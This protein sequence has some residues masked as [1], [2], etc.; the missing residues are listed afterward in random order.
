MRSLLPLFALPIAIAAPVL[1]AEPVSVPAFRSIQLRGGGEVTVRPGPVQRVTIVEGSAAIT[2]FRVERDA[3]LR[4]DVCDG[5]CPRHYRLRIDIQSPIAPDLAI[6]GG[7]LIRAS[8]GFGPQRQLSAA[9]R[10]GGKIDALAVPASDVSAAVHGGGLIS[11]R[12]RSSLAAAVNGG[13]EVRYS[14][15][16]RVSSAINGGGAV[17]RI[18]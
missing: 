13:G 4:I 17:H 2:R 8:A 5:N 12:A 11:V 15:S 9:V 18:N 1:A 7:G 3:K 16:P 10:G 14:G 6:D